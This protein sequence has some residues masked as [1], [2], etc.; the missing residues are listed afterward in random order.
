M[1]Y[2]GLVGFFAAMTTL[3]AVG[4]L[5]TSNATFAIVGLLLGA[6]TLGFAVE[7]R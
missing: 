6:V 3:C 1:R 2:D 5:W 7:D 4:L